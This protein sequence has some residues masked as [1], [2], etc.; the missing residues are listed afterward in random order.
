MASTGA[1]ALSRGADHGV[2]DDSSSQQHYDDVSDTLTTTTMDDEKAEWEDWDEDC[3][4]SFVCLFCP[5]SFHTRGETLNHCSSHGFDLNKI[6][7]DWGIFLFFY[8][9]FS[10][11]FSF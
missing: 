7:R 3:D 11:Q 9:Y 6:K 1:G 8:C 5:E 2:S 4:T 10:S